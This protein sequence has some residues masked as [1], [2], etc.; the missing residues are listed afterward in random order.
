MQVKEPYH[1]LDMVTF[2]LQLYHPATPCVQCTSAVNA[3]EGIRQYI[4]K[5]RKAVGR[6][7]FFSN[8]L[9]GMQLFAMQHMLCCTVFTFG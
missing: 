4:E 8:W 2:K 9:I 5:E 7:G 6:F 3:C 1:N